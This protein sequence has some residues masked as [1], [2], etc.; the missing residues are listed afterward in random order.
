MS[1]SNLIRCALSCALSLAASCIEFNCVVQYAL[2]CIVY[3]VCLRLAFCFPAFWIEFDYVVQR[4]CCVFN[5]TAFCLKFDWIV[6]LC[7]EFNSAA[8]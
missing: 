8:Y 5:L 3:R 7:T 4:L 2:D 6:Q 1:A